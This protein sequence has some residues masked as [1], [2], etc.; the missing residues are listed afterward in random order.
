MAG[1][2]PEPRFLGCGLRTIPDPRAR[3]ETDVR[4][5]PIPAR[6]PTQTGADMS[7]WTPDGERPVA[8]DDAGAGSASEM[9][10]GPSLDDLSP[11]ER[12]RAEEMVARM[13]EVQR[14]LLAHPAAVFVTNHAMGLYELAAV[15]LDQPEP[16]FEEAGL[17]IDALA[18]LLGATEDRLE[19][20][21]ELREA[22]TM[23]QTVFV[24]RAQARG[25]A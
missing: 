1:W 14:Q 24:Q 21:D 9:L 19:M 10:G 3:T 5:D 20:G 2:G 23:L 18:A 16:R 22:L 11:E 8:R 4:F 17:A 12:A 25:D 7:L 15:H 13:A 6:L